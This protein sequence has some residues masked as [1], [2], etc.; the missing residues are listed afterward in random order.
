MSRDQRVSDN[1]AL[2]WAQQEAIIR[3]KGLLVVFC[4]VADYPGATLSHYSFMLKGLFELKGKLSRL[5]ISF[6]VL[7]QS[8]EDILPV[9]LQQID[10]HA[11]VCDFDP[12]R[13]KQRWKNQLIARLTVPFYE[14]DSS[15]RR[16]CLDR[17]E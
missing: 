10:A 15:Q 8:P 14:V 6:Q 2:L 12:L 4:L 7:E 11:L 17:L 1:W 16:S 3:H 5:N 13:I 9:F